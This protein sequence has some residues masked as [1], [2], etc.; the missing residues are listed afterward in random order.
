MKII[1]AGLIRTVSRKGLIARK[2][3]P[4]GLFVAGIA[5]TVL[6]TVL[7]CRAT[8]KLEDHLDDFKADLENVERI[9][10]D[11]TRGK[12]LA[13]TYTVHTVRIVKLYAPSVLV[14]SASIAALAGSHVTL[15]RRNAALTAAYSLLNASY[16]NYRERIKKELGEEKEL[17]IYHAATTEQV[18]I[19][20][21]MQ[22][23]KRVNP[24]EWSPYAR[25]F[26]EY[27]PN[28]QKEAQYNKMFISSF[29]N[30][31]NHLLKARG[32]VFLNEVYDAL[33]F[34]RTTAGQV[35]GWLSEGN[36]D[37]FIDFG[38][39]EAASTLFMSGFERSMVLDFNVDGPIYGLL[40]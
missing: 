9:H 35:V 11:D 39:Y 19:D 20:G 13:K 6:S 23:L 8:L 36:G 4:T 22:D 29:Q 28:W 24:G 40:G 2:N 27:N 31:F 15:Q 25:I 14:G 3:A 33:G 5:G 7:A 38:L 26:D 1:P 16:E 21:K 17:D 34:K 30:Y 18:A 37:C 12:A 10:P 32:H